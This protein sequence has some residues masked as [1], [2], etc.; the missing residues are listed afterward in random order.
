MSRFPNGDIDSA[1]NCQSYEKKKKTH[2]ESTNSPSIIGSFST[3]YGYE[4]NPR[5][6]EKRPKKH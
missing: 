5:T 6:K 1:S 2:K 4:S 3:Y